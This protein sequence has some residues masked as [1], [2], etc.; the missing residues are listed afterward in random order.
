MT[1]VALK[2]AKTGFRSGTA[3][4]GGGSKAVWSGIV[5]DASGALAWGFPD[6][7]NEAA[8]LRLLAL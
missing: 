2:A 3:R 7:V 4:D 1:A 6:E 5:V 8:D